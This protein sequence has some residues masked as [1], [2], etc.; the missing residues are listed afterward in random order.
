M[1]RLT[2]GIIQDLIPSYYDDLTG[3]NVTQMM[4]EHLTE[5]QE[6]RKQ[7]E[8]VIRQREAEE[9]R[10]LS[11]GIRFGE[12]IKSIRYYVMGILIGLVLPIVFLVVW[13]V[14]CAIGSYFETMF[15]S[16][17]L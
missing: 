14:I 2:C 11:K 1:E 3:E 4:R 17:F 8:E 9:S 7:Y 15:Y 16:Y 13:Y 10:E 12:K 5:C 6:C